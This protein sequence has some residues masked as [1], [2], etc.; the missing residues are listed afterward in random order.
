[1]QRKFVQLATIANIDQNAELSRDC[2]PLPSLVESRS[3]VKS[4]GR[5]YLVE[6]KRVAEGLA[7]DPN[8]MNWIKDEL[9]K[10][11]AILRAADPTEMHVLKSIGFTEYSLDSR[12]SIFGLVYSMPTGHIAQYQYSKT[13]VSSNTFDPELP[14]TLR[15]VLSARSISGTRL[16]AQHSLGQRFKLARQIATSVFYCHSIGWVHKFINATNILILSEINAKVY[17]PQ[18]I[19]TAFLAGF[20]HSRRDAD[21]STGLVGMDDSEY[22]TTQIYQHPER[23]VDQV[24]IVDIE[25]RYAYR[26]DLYSLGVVLLEI[27]RWRSFDKS[28]DLLR[29]K[30]AAERKSELIKMARRIGVVVGDRYA[31]VVLRC[32]GDDQLPKRDWQR[33]DEIREILAEL[34]DLSSAIA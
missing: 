18:T 1:L 19:G 12:Q 6:L 30:S 9:Y 33:G 29:G 21:R 32:L 34:E 24:N 26:H 10:L 31:R 13:Q 4:D 20:E 7:K 17:F 28:P 22:W 23:Q 27:A 15:Q 11:A 3:L 8:S 25:T 14:A 16:I 2:I 5:S